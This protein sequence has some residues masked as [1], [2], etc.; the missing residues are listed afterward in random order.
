M[1]WKGVGSAL[2]CLGGWPEGAGGGQEG[3]VGGEQEVFGR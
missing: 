1:D 2:N 3:C